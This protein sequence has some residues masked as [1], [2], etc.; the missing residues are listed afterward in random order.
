MSTTLPAEG[1]QAVLSRL[2]DANRT[3]ARRYPGESLARQPVHT[4]YG[5]AHLFRAETAGRLGTLALQ[6]LERHAPDAAALARVLELPE[7]LADAVYERV[8]AKLH[9][10]PV[11][12]YRLD[13]EDGFGDRPHAEEDA[14]ALSAAGEVARGLREGTLPASIGIRIKSLSDETKARSARTLDMFVSTVLAQGGALPPG[15]VVTLPKVMLPEQVTALVELLRLLERANG[16]PEGAIAV[17]LM[18]ESTQAL[19]TAD[20]RTNL[21]AMLAAAQGR[22]R[23]VHLGVF[24]YTASANITAQHQGPEHPACDFARHL[25]QVAVTGTGACV[26][27]GPTTVIPV[28]PTADVHRAWRLS[29]RAIQRALI[30]GFY[31][32]WD[33]HPAQIPVRYAACYAFFLGGVVVA[34]ERL[35]NFIRKAGQATMVGNVFDDAATGQGLLNFFLRARNCGAVTLDEVQATGLTLE[36]LEGRSFL[37]IVEARRHVIGSKERS[38]HASSDHR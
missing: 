4:V 36:E 17:E 10:E 28:G 15:F 14:T 33:L 38:T 11:E 34:A 3:L 6:S 9:R 7:A 20:G 35:G 30:S 22:C 21:P 1:L 8:V 27:D 2:G 24:D 29:Y 19:L 31:Q 26:A 5:G 25:M 12:D 37:R 23:G 32:G 18:I 16:L 13:F